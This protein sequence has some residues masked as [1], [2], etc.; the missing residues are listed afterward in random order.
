MFILTHLGAFPGNLRLLK[1]TGQTGRETLTNSIDRTKMPI[2]TR[3]FYTSAHAVQLW[4]VP[5]T[6][7]E[8]EA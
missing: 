2:E 6:T 1:P 3:D 5:S 8:R 7:A 4:R